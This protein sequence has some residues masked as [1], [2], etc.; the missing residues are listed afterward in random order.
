MSAMTA[1]L[2]GN[3]HLISFVIFVQVA[4]KR[5]S[6]LHFVCEGRLSMSDFNA[7]KYL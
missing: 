2:S 4:A 3:T 1:A 6:S 7:D 5:Y